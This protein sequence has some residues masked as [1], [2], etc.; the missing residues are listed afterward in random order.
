[1]LFI[2]T[3]KTREKPCNVACYLS[4]QWQ[5]HR[6]YENKNVNPGFRSVQC[7]MS[8]GLCQSRAFIMYDVTKAPF[9]WYR[10]IEQWTEVYRAYN[11]DILNLHTGETDANQVDTVPR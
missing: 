3:G 5:W 6:K 8:I 1:M 9:S 11:K 4:N 10:C 2:I 7:E